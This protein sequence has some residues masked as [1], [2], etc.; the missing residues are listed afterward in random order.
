MQCQKPGEH[1][2]VPS[3]RIAGTG[4]CRQCQRD[5]SSQHRRRS[6]EARVFCRALKDRGIPLDLERIG[7]AWKVATAL[8]LAVNANGEIGGR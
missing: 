4:A 8:D 2:D 6:Q 7:D 5:R 1:P 3:N